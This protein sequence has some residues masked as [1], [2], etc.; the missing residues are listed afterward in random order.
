MALS[1]TEEKALGSHF[2]FDIVALVAS[3]GGLE[4]LST[5]LRPLPADFPAAIII[6][7]HLPASSSQLVDILERRSALPVQ[8][9][10]HDALIEPSKVTVCPP[11]QI[12]VLHPDRTG[13]LEPNE[14]GILEYPIDAFLRSLA[15][16]YGKRALV[17]VLTGMGNDGAAGA[18]ALKIAGGTVIAQSADTAEYASMPNAAI[19]TG[20]VDL[21]VPLYEIA[22]VLIRVVAQGGRFQNRVMKKKRSKS[23]SPG[24]GKCA[25][26]CGRSI[27]LTPAL[28]LS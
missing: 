21:V 12:L 10:E 11:R 18:K 5:V 25:P 7:Q 13:A 19:A 8:W 15:D 3:A 6:V 22:S 27:G 9:A 1:D 14:G 20:A 24:Q 26:S 4:A 2:P 17:V 16:S 23:C 28:V